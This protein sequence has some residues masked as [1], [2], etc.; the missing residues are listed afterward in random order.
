MKVLIIKLG[1]SETLDPEIGTFPSLG[2]IMRTT[3]ILNCFEYDHVTWLTD[4]SAYPL[5]KDNPLINRLLFLDM[6][7]VMQLQEER[8]D[9]VINLEKVPGMCALANKINAWSKRGFRLDP[10]FGEAQAFDGSQ[11]AL[12]VYTNFDV[13]RKAEKTWQ[14][15]LF[16]MIGKE[17]HGEGY[18]LGYKPQSAPESDVGLNYQIGKKWPS[19]AWHGWD[20][21][22]RVLKEKGLYVSWQAGQNNLTDY[23]EWINR[24]DMIVTHDSLGLHLAIALGKKVVALFGP[25]AP[26]EVYLYGQGVAIRPNNGDFACLPCLKPK[27]HKQQSCMDTITVETVY[28]EIERGLKGEWTGSQHDEAVGYTR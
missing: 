20:D 25:T 19:K 16:D 1:Y 28:G 14:E 15:V 17:W 13:K 3:V 27:C 5:L 12:R 10:E 26:Q 18:V 8:F 4:K 23:M 7:S 11:E 21:L 22:Y 9:V 24:C 6:F 2:D